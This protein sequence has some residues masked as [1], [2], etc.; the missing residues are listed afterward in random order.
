MARDFVK[1]LNSVE[2]FNQELD[3]SKNTL[4]ALKGVGEDLGYTLLT[5]AEATEKNG[6]YSKENLN[7][8]KQQTTI[9]RDVLRVLNN[10]N[11]SSRLGTIAAKAKLN[12][13]RLFS[14]K[15]D[16]ITQ[17]LFEQ[18]DLQQET[19]KEQKKQTNF[20]SNI[21]K[22]LKQQLPFGREIS[23][24]FGK[25]TDKFTKLGAVIGIATTLLKSFSKITKVIGDEF[26]ALGMKNEQFKQGIFDATVTAR[27]LGMDTK[28][29]VDVIKELTTNFG[30]SR[31]EALGLSNQI[32]DTSRAIGVSNQEGVKL[33]GS[34]TEI[35][36]LSFESANNFAK[37]TALLA[38][39]NNAAPNAVIKD[40]ADSSEVIAKFTGL[41]PDNLAKAAIQANK[42]GL[43]LKDVSGIAESL[44]DFESSISKELEASVLLGRNINLQKARE[45]ALSNDLQGLSIEITKQVGSEAEFNKLNLFQRRALANA[46]GLEVTQLSK[47]INNQNKVKTISEAIAETKPFEELLGRDSLDNITKI[48]NDFKTIG[49]QL[50]TTFGPSLSQAVGFISNFSKFLSESTGG[51]RTLIALVTTLATRSI[52][53]AI[54][55]LFFK[56]AFLPGLGLALSLGAVAALSARV[57]SAREIASAQEGGIT[58]KEGLVNVH[59]QE[60]IVP[61][62]QLGG[63]I[64]TAMTPVKDEISML[65]QE[66]KSYF[67]FGGSAVQGISR[68]V[69]GGI[70]SV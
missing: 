41:T 53:T 2:K 51:A 28:D 7:I 70:K 14:N 8:A 63:M 64:N 30:F 54:A 1:D 59:P 35:G 27:Q 36:G 56:N 43:N 21:T 61:I 39:A 67:G 10:Q 15:S 55:G 33:L 40:I 50:V 12:F 29:V 22:A 65:R 68:G 9:G 32:I 18:Y 46:V 49:V 37:Q 23:E 13:T 25:N 20:V 16:E 24:I 58:T 5:V 60:A 42:L 26:G 4:D 66:M 52:A 31:D 45:L 62:E 38:Q 3:K 48:V 34:L 17:Q 47:V 11:K 44:L 69:V 57:S 6:N 19:T